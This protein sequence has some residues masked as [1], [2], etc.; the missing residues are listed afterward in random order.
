[1]EDLLVLAKSERGTIDQ[2]TEPVLLPHLTARVVRSEHARWPTAR[3]ALTAPKVVSP[4][5]G[6]ETYVEQ[7]LRNLLSNAAKYG[8]DGKTINIIIDEGTE[9]VRVRVLDTGP[10]IDEAEA[11]RLFDLF[12]LPLTGD[13]GHGQWRGDR[14]LR[15]QGPCRGYGRPDLGRLPRP[16]GGAEFGFVLIR[17]EDDED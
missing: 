4:V 10:G 13:S 2:T 17:S 5:R 1:M 9:G 7:V 14:A 11:A 15:V 12:L 6:E 3:F 8:E 16:E